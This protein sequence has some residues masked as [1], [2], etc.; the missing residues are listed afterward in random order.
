V[1]VDAKPVADAPYAPPTA[2]PDTASPDTALPNAR[3]PDRTALDLYPSVPAVIV[4]ATK[5][6]T[7]TPSGDDASA[8]GST[9]PV[10]I[11]ARKPNI[12]HQDTQAN[13]ARGLVGDRLDRSGAAK[14]AKGNGAHVP[15][16]QQRISVIQKLDIS[17]GEK[18]WLIVRRAWIGMPESLVK[19]AWGE[20]RKVSQTT[21][22]GV[23][24]EQW[25]YGA[26]RYLLLQDSRLVAIE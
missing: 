1:A 20:P 9:V 17:E 25:V 12:R 10:P 4:N 16:E 7:P 13:A 21:R 15:A 11:P 5:P 3:T 18:N 24:A 23:N 19:Y 6:I 2:S 8:T 26:G 14:A 22:A